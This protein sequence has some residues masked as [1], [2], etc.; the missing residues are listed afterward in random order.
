[1]YLIKCK[2]KVMHFLKHKTAFMPK[3]RRR[4]RGGMDIKFNYF[5]ERNPLPFTKM[6]LK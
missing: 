3:R 4:R 6:I 2:T 5:S 1:M